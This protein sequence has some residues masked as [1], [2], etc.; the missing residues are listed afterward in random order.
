MSGSAR[1]LE[2]LVFADVICPW[3][4]V[5]KRRLEKALS[6]LGENPRISVTWLPFELNPDM[7]REGMERR[8]YRMRKF[9]SWERSQQLDAQLTELGAQEGLGF[10]YDLMTRTPNTLKAH[11][12]IW[13]AGQGD[14]QDA[15]VEALFV[16][17]FVE[18]R[19]IGDPETLA[20][21]GTHAGMDRGMTKLFLDGEDGVPEIRKYEAA[22]GAAGI[23]GVPAFIAN[24]RP[25]FMGAQAPEI[26][27][28]ALQGVVADTTV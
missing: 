16:G 23:T 9:G 4:Y 13:L 28:S 15:V 12:L 7:P 14:Q 24:R 5:G 26:L 21:I 6:M 11:R 17:Y 22:A 19:D 27:V 2:L 20:D 10:R 8:V 3:C 18:G 25:L 1:N